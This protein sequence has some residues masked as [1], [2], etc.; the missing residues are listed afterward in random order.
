MHLEAD[1]L[2]PCEEQSYKT[3][4]PHSL[5]PRAPAGSPFLRHLCHRPCLLDFLHAHHQSQVFHAG[6]GEQD[7]EGGAAGY[8]VRWRRAAPSP[9]S[10]SERNSGQGQGLDPQEQGQ[11]AIHCITNDEIRFGQVCVTLHERYS[12]TRAL[13]ERSVTR[14][15]HE[16]SVTR[17]SVT[18][19][20]VTR[21]SVTR[22]SVTRALV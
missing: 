1:G 6:A 9:P 20:S 10:H 2:L 16:R 17:A 21:A 13:H 12:D 7:H 11:G 22:A 4:R 19:A 3:R 15:L 18:R 5:P 8:V 14:A